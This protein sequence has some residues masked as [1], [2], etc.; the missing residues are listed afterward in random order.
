MYY[1]KTITFEDEWNTWHW[2]A[3]SCTYWIF[4][5][6]YSTATWCSS[7]VVLF[8]V[9]LFHCFHFLFPP[10]YCS[11]WLSLSGIMYQ[12]CTD[13]YQMTPWKCINEWFNRL[14]LQAEREIGLSV[15]I[16]LGVHSLA[17]SFLSLD[18]WDCVVRGV[19]FSQAV[20]ISW[21]K[22]IKRYI[23][24]KEQILAYGTAQ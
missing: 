15:P 18:S 7:L 11:A 24:S 22:G 23:L 16:M 21:W 1:A 17:W 4:K 20:S 14:T 13:I 19:Y 10:Y 3:F 6:T 12:L 8:V 2:D 9:K 5:I